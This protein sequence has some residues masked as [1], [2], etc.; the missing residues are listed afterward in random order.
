MQHFRHSKTDETAKRVHKVDYALP[1]NNDETSEKNKLVHQRVEQLVNSSVE[2]QMHDG[3]AQQV[4]NDYIKQIYPRKSKTAKPKTEVNKH[5]VDLTGIEELLPN[6]D[7][8]TNRWTGKGAF[9]HEATKTVITLSDED[10]DSGNAAARYEEQLINEQKMN[11]MVEQSKDYDNNRFKPLGSMMTPAPTTP[12]KQK[13]LMNRTLETPN[14]APSTGSTIVG[15]SRRKATSSTV[16]E[17]SVPSSAVR[18]QREPDNVPQNIPMP[19]NS[20]RYMA[21]L[22]TVPVKDRHLKWWDIDE[23]P[24]VL[25]ENLLNRYGS[26]VAAAKLWTMNSTNT[27]L[28]NQPSGKIELAMKEQ[29]PRTKV[30]AIGDLPSQVQAQIKAVLPDVTAITMLVDPKDQPLKRQVFQ[31]PPKE[32]DDDDVVDDNDDNDLMF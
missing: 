22:S 32:S 7:S 28:L 21:S 4:A 3:W 15:S 20:E 14:Y 30:F 13:R 17:N 23:I 12:V 6:Y 5:K 1:V 10:D 25:R 2:N 19:I 8:Q 16:V 24:I 11:R 29:N 26:N 9:P 27:V 18:R 31:V